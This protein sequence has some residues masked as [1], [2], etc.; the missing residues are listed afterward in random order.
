MMQESVGATAMR[1]CI[2]LIENYRNLGLKARVMICLYDA[3]VTVCPIEERH[4]VAKLHEIFMAET[5]TWEYHERIMHY[6]IDTEFV[7]RWSDK[8][9]TPEE[10][11]LLEC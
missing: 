9:K 7:F 5:N 4:I 10:K 6:P 2:W 11:K 1:A 3:L 8:R